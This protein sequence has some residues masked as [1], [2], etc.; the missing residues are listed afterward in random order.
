MGKSAKR[1]TNSKKKA[2]RRSNIDTKKI[3]ALA[4]RYWYWLVVIP[5]LIVAIILFCYFQ[6]YFDPKNN[7]KLLTSAPFEI[8]LDIG[9]SYNMD[10][11]ASDGSEVTYKIM[12]GDEVVITLEDN[13][14]TAI[15][16]G[17]TR[18]VASG[19]GQ[20]KIFLIKASQTII[21]WKIPL[22]SKY[23]TD[24][25]REYIDVVYGLN[26]YT[27][28]YLDT[29]VVDTVREDDGKEY[30]VAKSEGIALIE[31]LNSEYEPQR[32]D[33]LYSIISIK[34]VDG[35]KEEDIVIDE[36][37]ALDIGDIEIDYTDIYS[38]HDMYLYQK[39]KIEDIVFDKAG[40][41]FYYQRPTDALKLT[42][43][44]VCSGIKEG[45]SIVTVF[46][47]SQDNTY[48][49]ANVKIRVHPVSMEID[50][51]VGV[52]ISA[53]DLDALYD[54]PIVKY[55]STDSE[56][57]EVYN[58]PDG[59]AETFTP[60]EEGKTVVINGYDADGNRIIK[61]TINTKP[62]VDEYW[63]EE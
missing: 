25:I 54:N 39:Y 24:L 44:G 3:S 13:V 57:L 46:C 6:G 50:G 36:N 63:G 10:V 45:E 48:V 2:E 14:V 15:K 26:S 16:P 34:V 47:V 55:Y 31:I 29:D 19:G 62:N 4:K 49:Y 18:I 7:V 61:F 1:K 33:V 8:E 21:S 12:E 42:G 35:L 27:I 53:S 43:Y 5:L 9:K 20:S 37:F 41:I 60:K 56:Y 28:N 59:N 58:S 40:T 51:Y 52:E 38:V 23:E 11:V 17:E 32:K 22:G 30:F